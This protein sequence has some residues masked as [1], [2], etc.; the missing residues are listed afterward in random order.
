[1]EFFGNLSEELTNTFVRPHP[2]LFEPD[3]EE[4]GGVDFRADPEHEE[5]ESEHSQEPT[6]NSQQSNNFEDFEQFRHEVGNFIIAIAPSEHEEDIWHLVNNCGKE[7]FKLHEGFQEH[8]KELTRIVSVYPMGEE[9]C[10]CENDCVH[11]K[12][13]G[14]KDFYFEDAAGDYGKVEEINDKFDKLKKWLYA[15]PTYKTPQN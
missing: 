13:S 1:M 14:T 15:S 2:N 10:I 3:E 11:V 8:N 6:A 12:P 9:A 4:S 5:N 7:R